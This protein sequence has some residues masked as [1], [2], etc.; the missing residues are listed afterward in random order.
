MLHIRTLVCWY[1]FFYPCCPFIVLSYIIWRARHLH[2]SV[3]VHRRMCSPF[4]EK[5][6]IYIYI[7][8]GFSPF[9]FAYSNA[10]YVFTFIYWEIRRSYCQ[11]SIVGNR[12]Y[13]GRMRCY[14]PHTGVFDIICTHR[15]GITSTSLF[16][17]EMTT[18]GFQM[19]HISMWHNALYQITKPYHRETLLC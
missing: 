4:F 19:C 6:N 11:Q 10:S 14:T 16:G 5:K 13:K 18:W 17:G 7:W 1:A 2:A 15:C 8:G 12:L 3:V 9:L